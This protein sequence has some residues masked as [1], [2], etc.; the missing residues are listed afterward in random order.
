[1]KPYPPAWSIIPQVFV[2]KERWPLSHKVAV[3]PMP[4]VSPNQ[5]VVPD[6]PIL[7]WQSPEQSSPA[8][9]A[10][11]REAPSLRPQD[12]EQ[13]SPAAAADRREALPPLPRPPAS[14]LAPSSQ[15]IVPAGLHGRV[16]EITRRGGVVIES[17]A[18]VVQGVM[19]AGDQVAGIL[20]LWQSDSSRQIIPPGAI[21]V[22]PGPLN[23]MFLRQT[24]ASGVVGIVASSI[25]LR[26]LEGF[27]H[28]DLI[29]FLQEERAEKRILLQQHFPPLTL[30]FTE[31]LALDPDGRRDSDP[32]LPNRGLD[33]RGGQGWSLSSSSSLPSMPANLV[34]ALSYYQG[35]IALL[36]GETSFRD[37]I[38]PELIISLPP[39]GSPFPSPAVP[40]D[41]SLVPGA[42]A[43]VYGGE[44]QGITG[45]IDYLF[46]YE[47][48]FPSGLHARAARL[49]L[50][51]G[52]L[53]V[54]P[55]FSLE[56]IG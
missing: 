53:L 40:L 38:V 18:T 16:V 31:G 3:R 54:V 9:V 30:L 44:Y 55:L 49:R 27:L 2:R 42:Q 46:V 51:D 33:R 37:G 12:P 7:R 1:M 25:T 4:L 52:S 56:R 20:T 11:R 17:H 23:L 39:D 34:K 47:Q 24:V 19:G 14:P 28:V 22:V 43:R 15:E 32:S 26:D 45:T 35:S 21:L 29:A 41:T 48:K 8:A 5:Y 13:L 6:Q 50:E 36:S 10:D